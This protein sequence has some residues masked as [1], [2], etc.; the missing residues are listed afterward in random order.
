MTG[1]FVATTEIRVVPLGK[2]TKECRVYRPGD[3]IPDFADWAEVPR[4]AHLN[5]GY[6]VRSDDPTEE[7]GRPK[8]TRTRP[9]GTAQALAGASLLA[10]SECERPFKTKR[11][12]GAHRAR[13]HAGG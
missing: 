13:A 9:A 2:N 8:P 5:L 10:C 1:R 3:V 6:V 4:R 11:A 7:P 12:L